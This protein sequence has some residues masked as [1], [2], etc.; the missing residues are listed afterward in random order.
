MVKETFQRESGVCRCPSRLPTCV[1][2]A[3]RA[4][5]VLTRRPIQSSES[6]RA[7]NPRS[8]SARLRVAEKLAPAVFAESE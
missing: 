8:R 7:A 5:K 6:E 1:C 2:G 3:R 4:L